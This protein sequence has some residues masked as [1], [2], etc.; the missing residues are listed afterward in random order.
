MN[1][2]R[3]KL[4]KTLLLRFNVPVSRVIDILDAL[5]TEGR[6]ADGSD[7]CRDADLENIGRYKLSHADGRRLAHCRDTGKELHT[8]GYTQ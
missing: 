5:P 3:A 7:L 2:D 8:V 6:Y 4:C 1:V